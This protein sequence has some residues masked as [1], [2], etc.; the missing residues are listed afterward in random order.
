MSDRYIQMH[1]DDIR[2]FASVVENRGDDEGCTLE[3][4][5]RD[6]ATMLKRCIRQSIPYTY[7]DE[8]YPLEID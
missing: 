1:F 3:R 8:S 4:I 7:I 6:N 2:R 5:Q